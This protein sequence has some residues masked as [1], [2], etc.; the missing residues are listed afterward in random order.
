[1][2][3]RAATFIVRLSPTGKGAWTAVVERVKTGEKFRVRDIGSIGTLIASVVAD[4]DGKKA[5]SD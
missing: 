2:D 1:M 5:E 4:M 3:Q